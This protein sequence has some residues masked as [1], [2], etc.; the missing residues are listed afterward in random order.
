VAGA[1]LL[2]ELEN[3]NNYMKMYLVL[4]IIG[5]LLSAMNAIVEVSNHNE[6]A[7]L[8]W[9]SSSAY[10]LSAFLMILSQKQKC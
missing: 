4:L 7:A 1:V 10:T 8:G 5:F 6:S 9:G 2:G 3:K